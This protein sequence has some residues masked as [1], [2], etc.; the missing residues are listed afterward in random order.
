MKAKLLLL[1]LLSSSAIANDHDWVMGDWN[2]SR[3]TTQYLSEQRWTVKLG[4][5]NNNQQRLYFVYEQLDGNNACN[6]NDHNPTAI[7]RF[8]GQPVQMFQWCSAY[9]DTGRYY[10]YGSPRTNAG[11]RYVV[12]TFLKKEWV[13]LEAPSPYTWQINLSAK[14]FTKAWNSFGG[15]AL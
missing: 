4:H 1:T 10:L 9:S 14:G 8:N 13:Y 15:N 3:A 2:E 11:D 12:D 6:P 7:W 5:S